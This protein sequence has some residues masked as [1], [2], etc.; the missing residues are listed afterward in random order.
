MR[1]RFLDLGTVPYLES[2]TVYHAIA[3]A[4]TDDSPDTVTLMSPDRPYFSVG[5]LQDADREVDLEYCRSK[6]LPVIRR[7]VGGGAVYLDGNQTFLHFIFHRDRLPRALE[8]VYELYIRPIV[9]TYRTIGIDARHR[10]VNDIV[11]GERKIGGT[12][13]AAI[14]QA[15]VVAGSVMF[16][17]DTGTMARGLK[18]SSEK[19]RD[20]VF[21]SLEQYM[22][23]VRRELPEPPPRSEVLAIL[24][25][26]IA[27]GLDVELYDG[28]LTD[29]EKTE[30]RRLDRRFASKQWLEQTGGRPKH[31]V[32]IRGG[33]SVVEAE[34][35]APGGL[36]RVT[37]RLR[38][39]VLDDVSLS[40]DFAFYP[41]SLVAGLETALRGLPLE[42]QSLRPAV[43]SFYETRA[44]QAPGAGPDEIV[45]ALLRLRADS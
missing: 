45:R 3:Y 31:G 8:K 16:D 33:V 18:V 19:M 30:I 23:T 44:V 2:Q 10:P 37:A 34:H 6:A 21:E 39:E 20:K 17:F 42:E 5:F 13:V 22:T 7:E 29:A 35:K 32:L 1:V 43:E 27:G 14:G 40:G 9:E 41:L 12:G 15:M 24:R 25:D 38:D 4:M 11:V 26:K 28:E 36:I